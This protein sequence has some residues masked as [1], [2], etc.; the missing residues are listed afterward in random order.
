MHKMLYALPE[1][2]VT[3]RLTLRPYRQGDGAAYFTLCQN[4]KA[5]LLPFEAGNPA[6]SVSTADEAEILVRELAA[7]WHARSIFFMGVWHTQTG[8]LVAQVV[9]SVVN[10]HLPEFALG[11]FVDKDHEGHGYVTEACR[12]LI[13]WA[14]EQWGAQ[15][16]SSGCNELNLRSRRV[17]ERCG[18]VQEGLLRQTHPELPRA[19]GT[20]SG[21]CLF[22]LL[23]EEFAAR[24]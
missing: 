16:L 8:G 3:E 21:D 5:H 4:N 23:R 11:Y 17:L 24:A 12:A 6:L 2:L 14:F 18:F 1:T 19:D 9:L 10:W 22:G 20:P 7:D 13:R 15:R